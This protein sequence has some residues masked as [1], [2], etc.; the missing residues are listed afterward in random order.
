MINLSSLMG[1]NLTSID[2]QVVAAEDYILLLT[3]LEDQVGIHTLPVLRPTM[4]KTI[5]VT[6]G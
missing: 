5:Q 4:M 3:D 2:Q 6:F 1:T